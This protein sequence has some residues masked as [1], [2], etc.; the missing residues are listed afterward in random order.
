VR[1]KKVKILDE[2]LLDK[3]KECDSRH[4]TTE[5]LRKTN[6]ELRDETEKLT[7]R[8]KHMTHTQIKAL[9]EIIKERD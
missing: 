9:E 7:A 8:V 5:I 3:V 1:G 2:Q 6:E 4:K